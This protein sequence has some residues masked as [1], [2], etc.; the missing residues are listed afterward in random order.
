MFPDGHSEI[1]V[2]CMRSRT[3][4]PTKV[5]A[6]APKFG[7][8]ETVL[9]IHNDQYLLADFDIVVSSIG[10]AFYTTDGKTGH[11][12]WQPTQKEE[13]FLEK[14]G[15]TKRETFKDFAFRS[16]YVAPASMLQIGNNGVVCTR[17]KC[18]NKKACGFIPS[19]PVIRFDAS[20]GQ[21]TNGWVSI[22]QS[23]DLF[24]DFVRK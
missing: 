22:E 13:E 8:P 12:E 10:N 9:A 17:A 23:L 21:P 11:F 19:Y 24:K 16:L 2:K 20:T 5:K 3:L 1:R 7:I 6:L 14:I 15:A 18:R 4:G